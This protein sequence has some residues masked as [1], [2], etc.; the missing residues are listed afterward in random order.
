MADRLLIMR[1]DESIPRFNEMD[2]EIVSAVNR[3][4]LQQQTRVHVWIMKAKMNDRGAITAIM[5]QNPTGQMVL[6]YEDIIVKAARSVENGFI[7]VEGNE[8]W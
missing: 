2:E 7:D 5:Q 6:L 1:R 3:A 8:S 4:L